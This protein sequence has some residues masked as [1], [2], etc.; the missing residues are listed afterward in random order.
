MEW[1]E[2]TGRTVAE[3]LDAALD[4]LGVDEEDV[5]YQVLDEPRAGLLWRLGGR[6]ARVRARVR[7]ISREKPG[8]RRRRDR[9]PRGR[10][11]AGSR[12]DGGE[13]DGGRDG[14]GQRPGASGGRRR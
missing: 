14:G 11:T 9:R 8:D 2:T 7:P 5:E 4:E 10:A 13:R 12:E 3:A 6:E 1:V